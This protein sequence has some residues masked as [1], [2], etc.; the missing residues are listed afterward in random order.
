MKYK[1]IKSWW[2]RQFVSWSIINCQNLIF[3]FREQKNFTNILNTVSNLIDK[4]DIF[5]EFLVKAANRENINFQKQDI[6]LP[7]LVGPD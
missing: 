1:K 4:K 7:A 5:T 6:K 3:H 2:S